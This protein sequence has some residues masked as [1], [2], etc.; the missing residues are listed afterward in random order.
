VVVI[1]DVLS[2]TTALD[3]A[4]GRG[5]TVLP[6]RFAELRKRPA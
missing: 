6:Y 4:L 1:V 2:F 3:V 5:A